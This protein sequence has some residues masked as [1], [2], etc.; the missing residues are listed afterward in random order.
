L[1]QNIEYQKEKLEAAGLSPTLAE[2]LPDIQNIIEICK[3]GAIADFEKHMEVFSDK[4]RKYKDLILPALRQYLVFKSYIP[5]KIVGLGRSGVGKTLLLYKIFRNTAGD[6]IQALQD[7]EQLNDKEDKNKFRVA[8]VGVGTIAPYPILINLGNSKIEFTDIVG[9]GGVDLSDKT[10]LPLC[11]KIID[12]SD[13]IYYVF[14]GSEK[15]YGVDDTYFMSPLFKDLPQSQIKK[16]LIVM[17]KIDKISITD[18][19]G[20]EIQTWNAITNSPTDECLKI[21][22]EKVKK[23]VL[24]VVKKYKINE[25]QI[26]YCSA[27][28]NYNLSLLA[29]KFFDIADENVKIALRDSVSNLSRIAEIS[30]AETD[31]KERILRMT[32]EEIEEEIKNKKLDKNLRYLLTRRREEFKRESEIAKFFKSGMVFYPLVRI[33]SYIDSKQFSYGKLQNAEGYKIKQRIFLDMHNL[34]KINIDEKQNLK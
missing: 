19:R 15:D 22:E 23:E 9:F 32:L 16:T 33:K 24:H 29:K 25:D 13:L 8:Q 5:V 17:N 3:K 7:L 26:I 11:R 10:N 2:L 12:D 4:Y 21:V 34:L 30:T 20:D 18:N 14:N 28:K 27:I 6:N 1:S 31:Q